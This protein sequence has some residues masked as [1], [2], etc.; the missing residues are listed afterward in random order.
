MH[1][2]SGYMVGDANWEKLRSAAEKH[3]IHIGL[4]FFERVDNVIYMAQSLIDP[5]GKVLIHRHKLRPSGGERNIWSDGTT[6]GFQV[7]NT[8][9]G[10]IGMLKCWEHFHLSMTFPMQAQVKAIHIASWPY[11]PDYNDPAAMA[12]ESAEANMAAASLYAV[13][14]GAYTLLLAGPRPLA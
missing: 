1:Q 4:G 13:S 8:T 12:F 5:N 14:S 10:R 6:D 3:S 7:V 11:T 2:I 9:Y